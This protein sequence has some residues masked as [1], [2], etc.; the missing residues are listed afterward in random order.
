MRAE[1]TRKPAREAFHHSRTNPPLGIAHRADHRGS[2]R[3]RTV[4]LAP[5]A[6]ARIRGP[7]FETGGAH[8]SAQSAR[9]ALLVATSRRQRSGKLRPL[10]IG[11]YTPADA[12]R[13]IFRISAGL[14][15]RP[16]IGPPW[17]RS[18]C[19]GI[20]PAGCWTRTD[21]GR[22]PPT[23]FPI[24]CRHR[25]HGSGMTSRR[26]RRIDA[27]AGDLG[28]VGAASSD[29]AGGMG[30]ALRGCAGGTG[31]RCASGWLPWRLPSRLSRH[32]GFCPHRPRHSLPVPWWARPAI[33]AGPAPPRSA[34][35]PDRGH[36]AAAVVPAGQAPA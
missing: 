7:L 5:P 35:K 34:F 33:Y 15:A 12:V 29:G 24:P 9:V 21:G 16:A 19:C 3:I 25:G 18:L 17:L 8:Q 36:F 1:C 31:E 22:L 14:L 4:S 23:L 10:R 20:D 11:R 2:A 6:V 26:G 27:A 32:R 30:A 13:V 28:N